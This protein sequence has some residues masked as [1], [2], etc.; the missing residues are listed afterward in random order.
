[1]HIYAQGKGMKMIFHASGNQRRVGI[2]SCNYI[3]LNRLY[4][5]NGNM[6]KEGHY[7]MKKA[8]INQADITIINISIFIICQV[9][10]GRSKGKK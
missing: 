7:I 1:M 8:S 4:A 9:N 3:R 10:T 5:K 2:C 6:T